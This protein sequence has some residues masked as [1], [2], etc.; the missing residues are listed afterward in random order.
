[1]KITS[2]ECHLGKFITMKINTEEGIGGWAEAGQYPLTAALSGAWI[3]S[4]F[5]NTESW[6]TVPEALKELF[7]LSMDSSHYYRQYWYWGGEADL[8]VNGGKLQLCSIPEEEWKTVEEKAIP[9]WE[10]MAKASP[11]AAQVVE[12]FRTYNAVMAKAGKPYRY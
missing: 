10:E 5:A 7:K 2:V 1:M 9:F 3:G 8:R 6:N 12:A 4:C 11:R